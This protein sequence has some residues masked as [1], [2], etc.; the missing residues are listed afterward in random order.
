MPVGEQERRAAPTPLFAGC[1][2]LTKR[3]P[4]R[5]HPG[6]DPRASRVDGWRPRRPRLG[7]LRR[8]AE[9]S[10][11]ALH[12]RR[13]VNQR[14]EA[15]PPTAEAQ[16]MMAR[17]TARERFTTATMVARLPCAA[18]NSMSAQPN[19]R[20]WS[21]RRVP[22]EATVKDSKVRPTIA[23]MLDCHAVLNN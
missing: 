4:I 5:E 9:V 1:D 2:A 8:Q 17:R 18:R 13:L 10:Q 20:R 11:D 21:T 14:H 6:A 15:Q 22:R 19:R 12:H 3:H 7:D 23:R 16:I